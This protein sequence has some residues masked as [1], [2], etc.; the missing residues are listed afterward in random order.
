MREGCGLS[1]PTHKFENGRAIYRR[2]PQTM[3]RPWLVA[4]LTETTEF[5]NHILIT[6]YTPGKSISVVACKDAYFLEVQSQ[7]AAQMGLFYHDIHLMLNDK[8]PPPLAKVSTLMGQLEE[9]N[10]VLEMA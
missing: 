10:Y 7:I 8:T 9:A 2:Q 1:V 5:H 6:L 4:P 3:P